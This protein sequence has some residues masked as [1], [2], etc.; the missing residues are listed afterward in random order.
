MVLK[1][2]Q[3]LVRQLHTV[4]TRGP[5]HR[6][7]IG[8]ISTRI[9]ISGTRGKSGLTRRL[10][11]IFSDRGYDTAAKITGD[12][13]VMLHN[14]EQHPIERSG[15]VTMYENA[16]E[17]RAHTPDDVLIV[18]NQGITEYTNWVVN[19]F[20]VMPHIIVI[21]NIRQDHLDT[22]GGDRES[23]AR[24]ITRSIPSG[25][26]VVNAEQSSE[27]RQY[28][29]KR[30]KPRGISITHV[31][32]PNEHQHLLAAE[33]IYA[34]DEVSRI[35]DDISL[36]QERM[37]SY[38]DEMRVSWI[39]VD[40]GRVYN[41]ADVN[42]VEST[43][44][45]R[46]TLQHDNPEPIEVFMYLRKDRR[47]RTASFLEY[48]S[49]LDEEGVLARTH[50]TGPLTDVFAQKADF[51]V[52]QHDETEETADDV[53]DEMLASDRPVFLVGNTVA[54]FMRDMEDAI[55]ERAGEPLDGPQSS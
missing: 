14:G 52:V 11:D 8:N 49:R 16:R 32:I 48:L 4:A 9:V 3:N 5:R 55:N 19:D 27:L 21:P 7:I 20:Y 50:V 12:R 47:S 35:V 28:L 38:L 42:D 43:E 33:A 1:S 46:Q 6:E 13:P 41:A 17:I 25:I 36:S 31:D 26:H 37:Q 44:A 10:H 24:S 23:I 53:L 22:L 45:V 15:R 29:D 40:G 39:H 18:E 30:L 51:P 2:I 54:H 34:L